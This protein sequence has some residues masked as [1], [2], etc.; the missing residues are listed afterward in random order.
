M[1]INTEY[2]ALRLLSGPPSGTWSASACF[3]AM[4]CFTYN[5]TDLTTFETPCT[6]VWIDCADLAAFGSRVARE[7]LDAVPDLTNKGMCVGIY[8]EQDYAISY[9]PLDTLH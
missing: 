4:K 8:D 1:K 5:F 2:G 3:N 9:V 7:M 6:E